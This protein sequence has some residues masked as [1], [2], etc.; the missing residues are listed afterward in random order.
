VRWPLA[1]LVACGSSLKLPT[2]PQL[3]LTSH[4]TVPR[5]VIRFRATANTT[6]RAELTLKVR[7]WT[8]FENTVLEQGHV[9]VDFPA[10]RVRGPMTVT[11]ASPNGDAAI[12]F[13]VDDAELLD[14]V[15]DPQLRAAIVAR[16]EALRGIQA[17]WRRAPDGSITPIASRSKEEWKDIG[18]WLADVAIRF[19]EQPIGIGATWRVSSA[20]QTG[21]VRG[22]RVV[23]YHLRD[24]DDASVTIDAETEMRAGDQVL[25]T[26]PNA[27]RHLRSGRG[28]GTYHGVVSLRGVIAD[29]QAHEYLELDVLITQRRLRVQSTMTIETIFSTT[30]R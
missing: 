13:V 23:T 12:S 3:E 11:E 15:V 14:D 2:T 30:R 26:E 7:S 18:Q 21:E 6:E 25:S 8:T 16:T 20:F 1:L 27:T 28:T 5:E 29:G 10:V 24:R 9:D 22:L 19:P 17:S 4:G